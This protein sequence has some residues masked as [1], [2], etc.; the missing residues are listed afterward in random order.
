VKY[1]KKAHQINEKSAILNFYLASAYQQNKEFSK[2]LIYL[3]SAERLDYSNPM[4]K[5]QKANILMNNKKED[6]ALGILL[7]LN[8]KMPKEAPIHILIGR[9][10]K[11][12]KDYTKA[13]SHFNA[14]IDIDPKDSNLAKSLIEKLYTDMEEMN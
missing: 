6:E 4:I 13:L 10:Y 7:E 5:Y 14:A 1:F 12:K 2:A 3:K 9:I 8:E 11:T